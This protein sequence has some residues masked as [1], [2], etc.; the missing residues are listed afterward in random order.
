MAVFDQAALNEFFEND[1]R[2]SLLDC[3]R[4]GTSLVASAFYFFAVRDALNLSVDL[5]AKASDV[6]GE[7]A[8][9]FFARTRFEVPHD[10]RQ[11]HFFQLL[12]HRTQLQ[13]R[14]PRTTP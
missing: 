6:F 8:V 1:E 2:D 7:H 10:S 3:F 13:G 14:A 9:F 5:V 11:H 4:Q 12:L